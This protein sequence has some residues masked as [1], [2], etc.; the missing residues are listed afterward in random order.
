MSDAADEGASAFKSPAKRTTR[1][2]LLSALNAIRYTRADSEFGAAEL[3]RCPN[4]RDRRAAGRNEISKRRDSGLGQR[5][6]MRDTPCISHGDGGCS[7]WVLRRFARPS[8]I[9]PASFGLLVYDCL[10]PSAEP[11][12][13]FIQVIIFPPSCLTLATYITPAALFVG[14]ISRR[15][16]TAA[17]KENGSFDE[18]TQ[19][20]ERNK[21][22]TAPFPRLSCAKVYVYEFTLSSRRKRDDA[23]ETPRNILR[24]LSL[25]LFLFFIPGVS[26]QR[27][28]RFPKRCVQWHTWL[29]FLA[30]G[31]TVPFACFI[32]RLFAFSMRSR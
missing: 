1:S 20:L 32:F 26:W 3:A 2:D 24:P 15:R 23:S 6:R 7:A 12:G 14:R 21:W 25:S 29:L 10:F 4:Y 17:I 30:H 13:P 9:L 31:H 22:R 27:L 19:T 11:L 28:T 5:G 16:E 8:R 18:R